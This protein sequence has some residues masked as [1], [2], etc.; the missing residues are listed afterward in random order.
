MPREPARNKKPRKEPTN[1]VARFRFSGQ[2]SN[3]ATFF[4]PKCG[5]PTHFIPPNR[6]SRHF[7]T[8]TGVCDVARFQKTAEKWNRATFR[9]CRTYRNRRKHAIMPRKTYPRRRF[10]YI[11]RPGLPYREQEPRVLETSPSQSERLPSRYEKGYISQRPP[12]ISANI[13]NDIPDC[14]IS[15]VLS[16]GIRK[17]GCHQ[18][19]H[20]F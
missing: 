13:W 18:H 5:F 16:G 7:R 10:S 19:E 11:L 6:L 1:F 9:E 12:R 2:I 3:R 4:L 20:K 14:R 17:V 8:S 15:F